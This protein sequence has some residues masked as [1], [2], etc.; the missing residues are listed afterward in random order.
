[1]CLQFS[2]NLEDVCRLFLQLFLF[3]CFP[4]LLL[5]F[6]NSN[7][8]YSC[9]AARRCSVY[10]FAGLLVL[11]FHFPTSSSLPF[12]HAS[13][14]TPRRSRFPW[15]NSSFPSDLWGKWC[16]C[17]RT[18]NSWI[19]KHHHVLSLYQKKNSSPSILPMGPKLWSSFLKRKIGILI[20]STRTLASGSIFIKYDSMILRILN[21]YKWVALSERTWPQTS[22]I[23]INRKAVLGID[24]FLSHGVE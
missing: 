8:I 12:H 19:Q 21:S 11:A 17:A 2:S 13:T 22:P 4:F 23:F 18:G 14:N 20:H 10:F 9:P 3:V 24:K 15:N 16:V 5:S 6:G 7:R 1:M